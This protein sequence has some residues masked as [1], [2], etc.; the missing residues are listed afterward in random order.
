LLRAGQQGQGARHPQQ[1]GHGVQ[2][3]I[4]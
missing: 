1:Q 4:A 2:Q 3:L